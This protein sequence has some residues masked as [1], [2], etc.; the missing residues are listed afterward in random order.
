MNKAVFIDKDGTLVEDIPYNVDPD[1]IQFTKGAVEALSLLKAQGFLLILV[2]NQAGVA[3][4]YFTEDALRK[5][6]ASI[7]ERL[8]SKGVTIDGFYFCPHHP[9]GKL[10]AYAVECDCR[11][12]KPGMILAAARK[13][14]ID[15]SHSWM[16]GDILNDVEAGNKAGCRTILINN[17]NETIWDLSEYR[18]P[19]SIVTDMLQ[20]ARRI[21]HE[22]HLV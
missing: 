7:Q 18:L 16:I 1:K 17:G 12:P 6:Q 4:G 15:L 19:G 14:N 13:H 3:R 8:S 5:L 9:D 11:K 10:S 21:I 20:A 2:S 22:P